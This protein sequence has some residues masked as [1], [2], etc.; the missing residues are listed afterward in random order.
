MKI[1]LVEDNLAAAETLQQIL[2]LCNHQVVIMEC[3]RQAL[4]LLEMDSSIDLIILDHYMVGMDSI[5]FLTK[6]RSMIGKET[7]PVILTTGISEYELAEVLVRFPTNLWY[8]QKPFSPEQLLILLQS[9]QS[10]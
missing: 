9:L 6:L 7:I 8:F 3:G 1:L 2:E 10:R 4:T 5:I